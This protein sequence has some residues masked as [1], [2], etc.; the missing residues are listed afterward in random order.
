MLNRSNTW[1]VVVVHLEA[2]GT[3][4]TKLDA[5]FN[6][7]PKT[8]SVVP[9]LSE[10]HIDPKKEATLCRHYYTEGGWGW[11]VISASVMV[12][13]LNHGLQLSSGVLLDPA[14]AKFNARI[15]DSGKLKEFLE[16]TN[17]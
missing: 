10:R 14:A 5:N 8:E 4:T 17:Y 6:E 16:F 13:I 7:K 3:A 11:M 2:D 9:G 15:S 1:P 12:Q